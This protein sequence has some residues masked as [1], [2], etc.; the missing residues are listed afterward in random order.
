MGALYSDAGQNVAQE[1]ISFYYGQVLIGG[2]VGRINA[3]KNMGKE[4]STLE[5]NRK[6]LNAL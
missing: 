2:L 6:L 3:L 4:Y 5:F 1:P